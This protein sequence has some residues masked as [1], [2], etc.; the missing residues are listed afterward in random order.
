MAFSQN[1]LLTIPPTLSQPRFATYLDA[2]AQDPQ[3]AMA[4]YEWNLRVSSAFTTAL[5]ILE[6]SVRNAAVQRLD[7]VYGPRWPWHVG[8]IRS[9]PIHGRYSPRQDLVKTANNQPTAGKVVAELKFVFW[10]KLFTSRHDGL[11]WN[12]HIHALFPGAPLTMTYQQLRQQINNDIYAIREL[13]NRI[14]HHEPIFS[15]TLADDYKRILELISWRD[16][17]TGNWINRIQEVTRLLA[18]RPT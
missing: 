13:R 12:N 15:R 17:A 7:V 16:K 18:Q 5:H 2:R 10:E 14:A 11:L 9:V 1:E 3:K 4:L 6:I 8:F